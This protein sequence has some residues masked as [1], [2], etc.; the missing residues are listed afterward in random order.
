MKIC[1]YLHAHPQRLVGRQELA[2]ALDTTETEIALVLSDLAKTNVVFA[3][4]GRYG[5]S[6]LNRAIEDIGVA[7]LIG[8][9]EIEGWLFTECDRRADCNCLM[10]GDCTL[11]A[12]FREFQAQFMEMA[13]RWTLGNLFNATIGENAR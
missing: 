8:L 11:N 2:Y 5:G 4:R 10:A 6:R 12:M 3:R 7:E 9:G 1:L 13:E